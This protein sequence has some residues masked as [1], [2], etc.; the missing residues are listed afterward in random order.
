[1]FLTFSTYSTSDQVPLEAYGK[2]PDKSLFVISPSGERLAYRDTSNERDIVVMTDMA[3]GQ[4]LA[5]VNVSSVKPNSIYFIDENTLIFIASETRIIRG[6]KGRH[7][8][9]AAFAYKIDTKKMHQL[10]IQGYGIYKGQ[11]QLGRVL[12]IS[13]DKKY[14]YMPAY[15]DQANY[16]LYKVRLDKKRQP[17][18]IQSGTSDAIDYFLD[19]QG[20]VIARERFHNKNN[21]HRIESKV[22]GDW[23]LIFSEE[24]EYRTKSFVGITP[25]RKKLVMLGTNSETGRWAYYTMSLTDGTIAGPIFSHEDKDIESVLTDIQR[26]VHGVRYSGFTPSYEF[27]DPKLNARMRGIKKA[28]PNNS[29]TITD[30][31]PSWE[32]IVFY[33]DGEQSSGDYL[34]YNKGKLEYLAAERPDIAST[35]VHHVEKYEFTARDGMK[36]PSLL[37]IPTGQELKNL[38]AILM[39]HGGPES[40]DKIAFNYRAQFFA[41]QGYL[42]IQPQFRGSSGFGSNHLYAGRG[43]WGQKM[44]DDLTDAVLDLAQSG[45]INK[46]R[47]CIVGASYG[48]YAALAGAVF[49]PDLYKCVVSINGVSDVEEMLEEEEDNYGSDHW[50]VA[51]WKEVIAEGDVEEDHLEHISPINHVTKINAPVLLIHGEYDKVVPISQSEDMADK[52]EDEDKDVT[53][54]ELDKGDHHLSNAVNRM[55]AMREIDK[56]LKKHI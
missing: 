45:K 29:F 18:R 9:S 46:D 40:Y 35:S 10:L 25:D 3:N 23:Q 30:Y 47:V 6:F 2:L 33:M 52:M 7:E 51:Y 43:E 22:S 44:Q 20:N 41:S 50:V 16:S 38:P 42:V 49:T 19:G 14:A 34:M 27:F 56:F 8:I 1:M 37:T 17:K 4:L 48:G 15:K 55:K 13:P 26:V 39:P 21:L 11:S 5:A 36:I 24:T 28:M 12:G 54:I 53:F 31:T 32:K